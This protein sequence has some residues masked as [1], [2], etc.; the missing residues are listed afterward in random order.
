MTN[1]VYFNG[2][3]YH[4]QEDDKIHKFS[5][6]SEV[7]EYLSRNDAGNDKLYFNKIWTKQAE[8]AR[9]DYEKNPSSEERRVTKL[10]SPDIK[11]IK[12]NEF[13][14][15]YEDLVNK[16]N[17]N[18]RLTSIAVHNYAAGQNKKALEKLKTKPVTQ[19]NRVNCACGGH[20]LNTSSDK[21]EHEKTKRHRQY[22]GVS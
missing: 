15:D 22:M 2:K 10:Y 1:A 13:D 18:T 11:T 14:D 19:G 21:K 16:V 7:G 3:H 4:V 6:P 20:Y 12:R 8:I 17:E 5:A 9:S